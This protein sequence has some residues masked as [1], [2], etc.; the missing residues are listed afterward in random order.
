MIYDKILDEIQDKLKKE[1]ILKT[2]EEIIKQ[3]LN[4]FNFM[5][6]LNNK[7][8]IIIKNKITKSKYKLETNLEEVF[9]DE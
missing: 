2:D 3:A 7:A 1:D 8:K 4:L 9:T 5:Y 6:I